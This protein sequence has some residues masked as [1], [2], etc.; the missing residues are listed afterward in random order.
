MS[1]TI[2]TAAK[3]AKEVLIPDKTGVSARMVCRHLARTRAE[4]CDAFVAS[5][6]NA[7]H[8]VPDRKFLQTR[9]TTAISRALVCF[10]LNAKGREVVVHSLGILRDELLSKK[11]EEGETPA[12]DPAPAPAPA[13]AG[14]SAADQKLQL[15]QELLGGGGSTLSP[16]EIEALKSE[17]KAEAL[18][19]AKAEMMEHFGSNGGK[20]TMIVMS[21]EKRNPL[22]DQPKEGE[23]AHSVT[24][25]LLRV[26]NAKLDDGRPINTALVGPAGTGKTTLAEMSAKALGL[27]FIP[28]SCNP[29]MTPGQLIG[30][31][32]VHGTFHDG[33]LVGALRKPTLFLGDE[34]DKMRP[35]LAPM[36]NST[37]A[38]RKLTLP[39]QEVVECDEKTRFVIAMN[40]WGTGATDGYA[41]ARQDA[42]TMDRFFYLEIVRDR[43][44]EAAMCG[45]DL[46]IK[47]P[48]YDPER[49]GLLRNRENWVRFVWAVEDA[50]KKHNIQHVVSPRAS[51]MGIALAESGV[52]LH[53]IKEGLIYKGLKPNQ[54]KLIADETK[55]QKLTD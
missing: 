39:N 29:V 55:E 2:E 18:K 22:P 37:L 13:S 53:W 44:L 5:P 10:C 52:G 23:I 3:V 26:M 6:D 7:D 20:V 8:G 45:C 11:G 46:R 49:G 36:C 28:V 43:C 42:A 16:E 12:P 1:Y 41:S 54:R 47:G 38:N 14:V 9:G 21:D 19:D 15:L 31:K 24:P 51:Q 17:I 35:D 40:T 25:L 33:P 32:D 50:V 34:W 27:G 48:N 30:S 4:W